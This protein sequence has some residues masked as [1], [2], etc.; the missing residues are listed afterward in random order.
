[1]VNPLLDN[2]ECYGDGCSK[3]VM[4]MVIFAT[5]RPAIRFNEVEFEAR[6]YG[7]HGGKKRQ[8][9]AFGRVRMSGASALPPR[10]WALS[11]E[12]VCSD[13]SDRGCMAG[14][15]PV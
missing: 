15:A 6:F 9:R 2:G 1:M 5:Q 7:P 3:P 12:T 8:Y 13:P 11:V 10:R 4:E 14:A